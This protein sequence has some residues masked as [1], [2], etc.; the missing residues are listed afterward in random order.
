MSDIPMDD[1]LP[2]G[3]GR[4]GHDEG[5]ADAGAG[6]GVPGEHDGGADGGAGGSADGGDLAIVSDTDAYASTEPLTLDEQT[7]AAEGPADSGA[8]DE[9]APGHDDGGADGGAQGPADSGA[10]D[11]GSTGQ[12]DGGADGGA[13]ASR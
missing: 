5:P 9:T 4:L 2:D 12:H 6:A 10:G 8:G 11:P 1:Q 13:D 3:D 7:P